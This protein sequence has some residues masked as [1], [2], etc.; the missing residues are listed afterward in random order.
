MSICYTV[1]T[2]AYAARVVVAIYG[3]RL[4]EGR[5]RAAVSR[6]GGNI[7]KVERRVTVAGQSRTLVVR[8]EHSQL[9]Q[10]IVSAIEG[11]PGVSVSRAGAAKQEQD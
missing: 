6:A 10:G 11:I 2:V 9:L 3:D 8:I 1:L 7:E 4:T 5:M